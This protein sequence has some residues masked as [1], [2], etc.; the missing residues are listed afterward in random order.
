MTLTSDRSSTT[1]ASRWSSTSQLGQ[2][3]KYCRM[4]S[5]M[6]LSVLVA[7]DHQKRSGDRGGDDHDVGDVPDEPVPV[8]EEVHDEA[9]GEPWSTE[10]P[11]A[12]VGGGG[13]A[14]RADHDRPP[15]V[16]DTEREH[17]RGDGGRDGHQREHPGGTLTEG[18]RRA[19]VVSELQ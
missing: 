11:V 6:V 4:I 8:G 14:K 1:S 2:P 16:S 7:A 18:E 3:L 17:G 9:L 15:G 13:P 12:G 19:G 5:M 10:Q